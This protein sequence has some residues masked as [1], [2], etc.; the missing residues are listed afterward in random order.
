MVEK[1]YSLALNVDRI[2]FEEAEPLR[3]EFSRLM[4]SLLASPSK[5]IRLLEALHSKKQGLPREAIANI[6]DFGNG[7]NLTRILQELKESGFIRSYKPFGKAKNGA[8]YHLADPFIAFHLTFISKTESENY[9]STYTDNAGHRAWSGY[10]F[11]Q[12]CLAHI[13]QI[14]QALGISGFHADVSSWISRG[15]GK[16]AKIDLVIERADRVINL[17]EI[18]FAKGP[19]EIDRAY[20]LALR[21]KIEVFRNET[22][23]RK[24]I[25]LT[26][27]TTYGVKPGKY[28][29][30]AQSEVNMDE[31]IR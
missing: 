21:G 6:I 10:A 1:R 26:M 30:L 9:W 7:G 12:V 4:D 28:A 17:C 29:G 18:K 16:G 13:K 19:Y 5:H 14:K 22:K 25:H 15:D 3:G 31:L 23:T 24:A 27:I 20:D 11:E 8:L 2:C